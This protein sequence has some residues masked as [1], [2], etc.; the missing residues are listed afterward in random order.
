MRAVLQR[1]STA[2]VHVEG[3]LISRI[4]PGIV[5]LIGIGSDDTAEEIPRLAKRILGSRLWNQGQTASTIH[6]PMQCTDDSNGTATNSMKA[7]ET[8]SQA[9][10]SWKLRGSYR[11]TLLACDDKANGNSKNTLK[12]HMT[13]YTSLSN[14]YYHLYYRFYYKTYLFI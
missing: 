4:G 8:S 2:S 7:S 10:K 13:Y 1:A 6:V 12:H 3:R 14:P 11:N 9:E 5:A